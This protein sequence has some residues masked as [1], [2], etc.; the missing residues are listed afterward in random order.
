MSDK[1]ENPGASEAPNNPIPVMN[2]AAIVAVLGACFYAFRE[3]LAL[4]VNWWERFP[5]Y[6]HG[7][8]I[9]VVAAYLLLL[10]ADR[11]KKATTQRA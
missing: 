8:L 1:K 10:C 9:P 5:E 6:N 2:L 7:Y 4:M 11:F 3:G